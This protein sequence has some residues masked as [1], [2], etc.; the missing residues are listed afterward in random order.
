V[1]AASR[2]L[3]GFAALFTALSPLVADF[4]DTHLEN[5]AW[6]PHARFHG[7][8]LACAMVATGVLAV[9]LVWRPF[10]VAE[11]RLRVRVAAFLPAAVW[12]SFFVALAVPGT[13]SWP[14]G[15]RPFM[16]VAPN[17]IAAAIVVCMAT[18]AWRLDERLLARAGH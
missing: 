11:R 8:L 3:I 12:G 10:P 2:W 16:R 17:V 1:R 4:N 7:V 5:A 13:S 15:S 9:A 18:L 14:D 6:P